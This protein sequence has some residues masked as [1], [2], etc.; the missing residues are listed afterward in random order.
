MGALP[1]RRPGRANAWAKLRNAVQLAIGV[2]GNFAHP[3]VRV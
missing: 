3:T 1:T 2:P